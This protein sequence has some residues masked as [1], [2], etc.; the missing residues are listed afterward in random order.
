[1]TE[2]LNR[3]HNL[4]TMPTINNNGES[5]IVPF[6]IYKEGYDAYD[7]SN[8]FKGRVGDNGT[9]FGIRWYKHGQLMDVTGMRPF[10]EGQVGD[11][12]IDDSDPD[13]PKI[14]MDSEAS[15]V[16]VVGEVNDCQEYGVAIYRL[17]NQA[18][19][20]SG[21]FYG[22]I[23]VMGTQDDG[24]TVMSSVDVVFKVLA[25]HMSMVGARKFYVSELEKALLDFKAKIKQH[26]Q[27]YAALVKQHN[28]EFQ[29]QVKKLKDDTQQVIDDAR[30]TYE[31]ETKNAHDSLD[32]LKAQ[33]QANRDEQENLSNHLV[34]TEQ[35]IAEN[36]VV[37]VPEFNNLSAKLTQQ[38]SEMRQN[39]F[40]FFDNFN[41]L[42]AK[43][44]D[45]AN[46][47]CITLD[48]TH[49]WI[50]DNVSNSWKDTGAFNYGGLDPTILTGTMQSTPD[51]LIN[52][53]DFN[54]LINWSVA[55]KDGDSPDYEITKL[56]AED[57]SNVLLLRNSFVNQ[58]SNSAIYAKTTVQC[59]QAKRM[60]FG[61]QI[62]LQGVNTDTGAFL[63]FRFFDK[64]NN[65][66]NSQQLN[67]AFKGIGFYKQVL[68]N[69]S[70]PEGTARIDLVF[71][72]YGTGSLEILRPQL[73]FGEQLNPYST[74]A[75][76]QNLVDT[77]NNLLAGTIFDDFVK[78]KTTGSVKLLDDHRTFQLSSNSSN[79]EDLE[80]L[81]SPYIPVDSS[82]KLNLE[83]PY[84][85]D[86]AIGSGNDISVSVNEFDQDSNYL[87]D[88]H[89]HFY[90]SDK[91][92]RIIHN[93]ISL[94]A[95][96]T[97]VRIVYYLRGSGNLYIQKPKL[98][99]STSTDELALNALSLESLNLIQWNG[100]KDG[101][102]KIDTQLLYNDLPT[103]KLTNRTKNTTLV[104]ETPKFTVENSN[105]A[106][107]KLVALT[108]SEEG[109]SFD[110]IQVDQNGRE[111]VDTFYPAQSTDFEE[112]NYQ[113]TLDSNTVNAYIRFKAEGFGDANFIS[114]VVTFDKGKSITLNPIG[115]TKYDNG[116]GTAPK[117]VEQDGKQYLRLKQSNT[118][119]Q[120]RYLAAR[121]KQL[122]SV[123]GKTHISLNA[124]LFANWERVGKNA[125]NITIEAYADYDS[126]QSYKN[127]GILYNP[128]DPSKFW[129]DYTR[130]NIPLPE[131]TKYIQVVLNATDN[132]DILVG[133]ID[134][135]FADKI[136][137]HLKSKKLPQLDIIGGR[138]SGGW[139]GIS[140]DWQ[141]GQ[142][143]YR[144]GDRQIEGYLDYA[145]QGDS[146]RQYIKKNLKL[147]LFKDADHSNKYKLKFKSDWQK[148]NKYNVK[149]NWIDVTQSR[150]LVNAKIF[151]Q[152]TAVTPFEFEDQMEGLANSQ[153]LGQ[154]EGI[155]VEMY[156][157]GNYYGL[158]TLN[159]K[160][161]EESFGMNDKEE[162]HEVIS[163]EHS[164]PF[165]KDPDLTIDNK[166]YEVNIHD[167]ANNNLKD[168]FKKFLTFI[169]TSSDAD[170]KEHIS[171]YID[172]G[173]VMNSY[174]YGIFARMQ[175]FDGKS[176][177]ICT[178]DNGITYYLTLYD[179]DSTWGLEWHGRSVD[180]EPE[181]W[182]FR[183]DAQCWACPDNLLYSRLFKLFKP[184]LVKQ[185]HYLR[186]TVWSN[187]QLRNAFK[188]YIDAIPQPA[189][190]RELDKWPTIPSKDITSL[191][192]IQ[193]EIIKRGKN[194]DNFME[195]L[196]DPA[197]STQATQQTQATEAK[198]ANDKPAT[199][200]PT[201]DNKPTDTTT[202]K[203]GK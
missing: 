121:S 137:N 85:A 160:K 37:T 114:P 57:S 36:D 202:N 42:V 45:G 51:N 71:V 17:I 187:W 18:M 165:A 184:E 19:P 177:M 194:M 32:A 64:A 68:P 104:L 88:T 22:K 111:K 66:F 151:E 178:W 139:E 79:S 193:K 70:I 97:S 162:G 58:N 8:W 83:I 89:F 78:Y 3:R 24:T 73:N 33:I 6:D 124:P 153:A 185:W 156:F 120:V 203:D 1:M 125:F 115:F 15:N 190:E 152:S 95:K 132:V 122:V 107:I 7:I 182:E 147:K 118:S 84:K 117:A 201:T 21:I 167:E 161:S 52:N 127:I 44:P 48:D 31:S 47:L 138:T 134:I 106:K 110:F 43:Y 116:F 81:T 183:A 189:Y 74:K 29:D 188:S 40:E 10:I 192:Q 129:L 150:N 35:K 195:H 166:N 27:E 164:I 148:S 77:S 87:G 96:T 23:G 94:N 130:E 41:S 133:P 159:T 90:N 63:E 53:S 163:M 92:Y 101:T 197:Q 65:Q 172:L 171:D 119:D 76:A 155:P 179:Y 181:K 196:T 157:N 98:S 62:R 80:M 56:N 145:V 14:N 146:S 109:F 50:Y 112:E 20:Q 99:Y 142:F 46:K 82:R 105:L 141:K 69:I 123:E 144:D 113:V 9:P 136:P 198:P 174:L 38:V 11:Y 55:E 191:E 13:D 39:G 16:H 149:A 61:A 126:A 170:F 180:F 128:T 91:W 49:Q 135:Y 25:G 176:M 59:D 28:Q 168:N 158:M 175:D 2:E 54:G 200:A 186:N 60:S 108:R 4:A 26:N 154:M 173:S 93:A 34:G 75:I 5:Y 143:V 67:F 103:A 30:S 199:P 72:L 12:T 86:F 140:E 102:A 131:G 169:K 100:V